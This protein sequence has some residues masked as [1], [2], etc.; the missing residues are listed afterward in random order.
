MLSTSKSKS[1]LS[2]LVILKRL[3][4]V[5]IYNLNIHSGYFMFFLIPVMNSR[6]GTDLYNSKDLIGTFFLSAQPFV[7]KKIC[8]QCFGSRSMWILIEM[9]SRD[10][11]PY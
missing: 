5:I 3:F 10:P 1:F 9:A 2:V 4:D 11:D 8:G 6:V 7:Y